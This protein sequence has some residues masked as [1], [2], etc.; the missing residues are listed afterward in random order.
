MPRKSNAQLDEES[1]YALLGEILADTNEPAY[2]RV[3]AGGTRSRIRRDRAKLMAEKAAAS[4]ERREQRKADQP[5]LS[6]LPGRGEGE[7]NY[8]ARMARQKAALSAD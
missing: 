4:A 3:K 5:V 8:H 1:D 6:W 7:A 2:I